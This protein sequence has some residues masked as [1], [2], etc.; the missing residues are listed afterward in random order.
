[1]QN[2]PISTLNTRFLESTHVLTRVIDGFE[3]LDEIERLPTDPKT[4]RPLEPVHIR[5]VIIHANPL[6]DWSEN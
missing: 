6:T 2:K 3:T 1:M 4:N 5:S